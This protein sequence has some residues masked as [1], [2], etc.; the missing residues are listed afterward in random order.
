MWKEM[1]F[2]L[3]CKSRCRSGLCQVMWTTNKMFVK[4]GEEYTIWSTPPFKDTQSHHLT[5]HSASNSANY[6]CLL[7]DVTGRI[8]DSVEQHVEVK[9]SGKYL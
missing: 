3:N 2:T 8:I 9:E 7:I 5:V 1:P 6:Q 4:N